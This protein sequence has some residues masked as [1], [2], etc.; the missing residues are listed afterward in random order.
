MH[1]SEYAYHDDSVAEQE[2]N[3]ANCRRYLSDLHAAVF[4]EQ[5]I[6]CDGTQLKLTDSDLG[7]GQYQTRDYYV[8]VAGSDKQLL[9]IFPTRISLTTI[10]LH[11]YSDSVRGLPRLRFYAVPDNF[12][13]WDAPT[14]NYPHA[15][16][17]AVPPGVEPASHRNISISVDF[18]TSKVLMYKLSSTFAFAVSEVEFFT[19][20]SECIHKLD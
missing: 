12:G 1:P 16:V 6:H 20:N 10:T 11:Y 5:Y 13:V 15:D 19:C 7:Q 3:S 18:S 17:A 9:F 8:W 2:S 14:T 4:T